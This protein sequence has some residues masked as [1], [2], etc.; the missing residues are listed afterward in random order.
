MPRTIA[1]LLGCLCLAAALL[2]ATAGARPAAASAPAAQ[3][4]PATWPIL[5]PPTSRPAPYRYVSWP[6]PSESART[7]PAPPVATAGDGFPIAAL[8][9]AAGGLTLFAATFSSGVHVGRRRARTA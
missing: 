1:R 7:A 9:A 5:P 8:V 6:I 2:P 4:T 3:P